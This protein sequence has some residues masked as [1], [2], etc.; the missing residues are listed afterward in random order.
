[1]LSMLLGLAQPAVVSA[2]GPPQPPLDIPVPTG[3]TLQDVLSTHNESGD[4]QGILPGAGACDSAQHRAISLPGDDRA[5][6]ATEYE[7]WWWYGHVATRD[8]H[9][10]AFMVTFTSRPWALYYGVEYNLTDL[11][12]GTYHWGRQ[13]LI[14]G[15][16]ESTTR[17]VQLRGESAFA[18]VMDGRTTLRLDIDG[19]ALRLAFKPAKPAILNGGDGHQTVYCQNS[20]E[21]SRVRMPT[22]GKVGHTGA[23]RSVTG[24][25]TLHHQWGFLPAELTTEIGIPNSSVLSFELADGRDIFLWDV[26]V[27]RGGKEI[28]FHTGYISDAQ[29]RVTT[30]HPGDYTTTPT[31]VWRRDATCS[32]PVEWDANIKGIHLHARASVDAAEMRP[33]RHPEVIALFPSYAK[34][35]WDGET[36]VSGDGSGRG[37]ID[38]THYCQI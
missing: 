37:W 24:T 34:P 27:R 31:R 2:F 5:H 38:I 36:I 29:G 7:Y 30:L 20:Y 21:Y 23:M 25:S 28:T 33:F 14:A 1:V 22:T 8:H 11:S 16:P 19:Y 13:P 35:Y 12:T 26:T 32:Y 3:A 4:G 15:R 10:L 9:R 6:N 17:G 18:Q